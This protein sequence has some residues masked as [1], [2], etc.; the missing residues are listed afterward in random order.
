MVF[1]ITS[2]RG[3]HE[4]AVA[5]EVGRRVFNKLTG[6]SNEP[7]PQDFKQHI[8][9]NFG[10]LDAL[11]KDGQ[12]GYSAFSVSPAKELSPMREFDAA[13]NEVLFLAPIVGG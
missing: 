13:V 9:A 3:H 7:L 12:A 4:C 6:L 11:W 8:P 5:Q 1:K 10:E 2:L